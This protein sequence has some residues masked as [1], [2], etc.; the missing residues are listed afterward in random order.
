[1]GI[2]GGAPIDQESGWVDTSIQKSD[3]LAGATRRPLHARVGRWLG[4][5]LHRIAVFDLYKGLLVYILV[6]VSFSKP[7]DARCMLLFARTIIH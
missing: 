6:A 7:D 5:G 3:D 2:S 4:F 1:L